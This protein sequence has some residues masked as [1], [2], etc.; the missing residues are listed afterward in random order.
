MHDQPMYSAKDWAL[1]AGIVFYVIG[2]G[3]AASAPPPI[4]PSLATVF[5]ISC[6]AMAAVCA[7]Y[8]A[9]GLQT[10]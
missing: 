3:I 9:R 5:A 10:G 4:G 7:Y 1:A 8:F 2:A 6:A